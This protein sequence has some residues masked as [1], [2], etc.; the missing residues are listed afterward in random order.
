M[1][2]KKIEFKELSSEI[3]NEIELFYKKNYNNSDVTFE[4]AYNVWFEEKF[5]KWVMNNYCENSDLIDRKHFRLDVE[6]PIRI[7]DTIVQSHDDDIDAVEFIGKIVNISKGGL[8]FKSDKKIPVSSIL[9][10]I[11]DFVS[12]NSGVDN[13]EALAMVVRVDEFE[14]YFGVALKFSSIYDTHKE[15][16]DVYLLQNLSDH[17]Y[18]INE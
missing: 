1:M 14:D 18:S 17:I 12:T 8:Y 15:N 9:K 11:V 3:K 5:D 7:L 10:V 13:I 6:I 4:M 16:L 2:N